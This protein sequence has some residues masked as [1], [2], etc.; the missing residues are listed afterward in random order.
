MGRIFRREI[1]KI[2]DYLMIIL[3]ISLRKGIDKEKESTLD[4]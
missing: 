2:G 1:T 4:L 3:D